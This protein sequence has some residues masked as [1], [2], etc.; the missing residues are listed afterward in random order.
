[1]STRWPWA[2]ESFGS[3]TI[4]TAASL[5]SGVYVFRLPVI[6]VSPLLQS[7]HRFHTVHRSWGT[8][9]TGSL[10]FSAFDAYTLT[11]PR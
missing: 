7:L 2:T 1:M 4:L 11:L 9:F 10:N 8:S 6:G 3:V 5:N